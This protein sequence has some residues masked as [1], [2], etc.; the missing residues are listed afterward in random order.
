MK[1]KCHPIKKKSLKD[2]KDDSLDNLEQIK[3]REKY[4]TDVF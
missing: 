4:N 1:T 2:F 3:N